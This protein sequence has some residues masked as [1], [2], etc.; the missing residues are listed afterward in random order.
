[1]LALKEG[2]SGVS[3]PA[4]FSSSETL[5]QLPSFPWNYLQPL[6]D[7][8]KRE[9]QEWRPVCHKSD[10]PLCH[11]QIFHCYLSPSCTMF[12]SCST[13]CISTL[14]PILL[15][16]S[17]LHPCS[18]RLKHTFI[19]N[20]SIKFLLN[21][22]VFPDSNECFHFFICPNAAS[23]YPADHTCTRGTCSTSGKWAR[24]QNWEGWRAW[25]NL[26]QSL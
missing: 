4:L 20:S 10:K 9:Y 22:S 14:S 18:N 23:P 25:W 6:E 7:N 17:F 8:L 24:R 2:W 3:V 19:A 5:S 26:T 21:P 1:M 16:P 12:L 15:K 11:N 13:Y